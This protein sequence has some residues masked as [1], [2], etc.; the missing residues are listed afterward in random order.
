MADLA[1][2]SARGD[3][4]G[5]KRI[6]E[7]CR[8]PKRARCS[9]RRRRRLT[10]P[11]GAMATLYSAAEPDSLRGPQHSHA[12]CDEVAKW[13]VSRAEATW[14]N[15]QLG[16]RL[17][18]CPR[19]LATTTPRAVPL[20]R[21]LVAEVEA[22][23]AVLTRGT[24]WDNAA[25]LPT[26]SPGPPARENVRRRPPPELDAARPRWLGVA[27]RNRT[28]VG[29]ACRSLPRRPRSRRRTATPL[30]SNWART[31]WM[32]R[33]SLRWKAGRCGYGRSAVLRCRT[34]CCSSLF[35][36][37]PEIPDARSDQLHQRQS[38]A[39]T[40]PAFRGANSKR[41]LLQRR[42]RADRCLAPPGGRGCGQR[43]TLFP[44]SGRMLGVGGTPTGAWADHAGELACFTAGAW[45]FLEPREGMQVLDS[46]TGGF[47]LYRDGT[48]ERG[49][50]A[51]RAYRGYH[52]RCRG[53]HRN[54]WLDRRARR[55]R[56]LRRLT[57]GAI[58][59]LL[60]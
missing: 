50:R 34:R 5:R 27:R 17:G 14:D 52:C 2:R 21:R 29:R 7:P 20:V 31:R 44:R 37:C 9:S 57:A 51:R 18:E 22:G 13:D 26:R 55:C 35:P 32:Q 39:R 40:C 45:I 16:L 15:L 36:E 43:S 41:V 33:R 6:L 25:N 60:R 53:P 58:G 54:N 10:W 42:R 30:G 23:E 47:V 38:A 59:P 24:T 8:S 48:L 28:A 12:W 3:G 1:G 4:R 56:N 46:S 11:G 19:A 49:D